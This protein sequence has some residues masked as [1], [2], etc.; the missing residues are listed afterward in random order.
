MFPIF[1]MRIGLVLVCE[2]WKD[3]AWQSSLAVGK[4]TWPKWCFAKFCSLWL[5][6]RFNR[7][8][9]LIVREQFLL[10]NHNSCTQLWTCFVCYHKKLN[11]IIFL[12]CFAMLIK[13]Y[14]S[15][16]WTANASKEL[17]RE[18]ATACECCRFLY[19]DSPNC[20]SFYFCNL[21]SLSMANWMQDLLA[22]TGV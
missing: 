2:F 20:E 8:K 22:L 17:H 4:N 14:W 13:V 6:Q 5:Y 16:D 12:R 19:A 9:F 1:S 21:T 10:K 15:H 7:Q 11:L 3:R 18:A